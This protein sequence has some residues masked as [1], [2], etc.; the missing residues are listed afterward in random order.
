MEV[1]LAKLLE[2][3]PLEPDVLV[4]LLELELLGKTP[5][6]TTHRITGAYGKIQLNWNSGMQ[7]F[8]PV[9]NS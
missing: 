5:G 6:G 9:R 1:L 4:E 2:Q 8:S 3:E 7:S